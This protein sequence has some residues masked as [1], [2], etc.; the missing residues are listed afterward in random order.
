MKVKSKY[1]NNS[2]K[3]HLIN[4][5]KRRALSGFI[6]LMIIIGVGVIISGNY[7]TNNANALTY[8]DEIDMQFTFNPTVQIAVSGDLIIPDLAPGSSSDSNIITITAGSNDAHG[9]KLYG[10]VGSSSSNYTDLRLSSSNTTNVFTNLS[11]NKAALSNFSDNTWGYSYSTDSG[12]SWVSGNAGS[13]SSGY[14]GLP[15]YNSSNNASGV[16]LASTNS[17]S[18]TSLQ[19]KI[20]AKAASTQVSGTYTN[21]INFI[22]VGNVVT[23]T[24]SL[25]YVDASGEGMGLPASL[26]SQTTN[27]GVIT[28]SDTTP[29][30]T[31]YIF[32]GWCDTNNSSDPTTCSGAT[33]NPGRI[34]IIPAA[35][36]GGTVTVNM[37]AIWEN[38]ASSVLAMQD[39]ATWGSTLSTGDEVTATD[40]RDGKEYTV[41]KLADGNIWMTTNLNIAGGTELSS[42][43]TDFESTYTLPTTD[44][45]TTNN[46]KLVLPASDSTGF[47][48]D[49]YAYVYNTGNETSTCTSPGCYSYYSWDAATLGSGRSISTDNTDAPY[50][51]CPKGWHLPNTYNGSGTA[52]EATDFRALMIALGGS[53]SV[54][55]YDSSTT[56]TGETISS[57]LQ[58]DPYNFL[59]G[60]YYYGGSFT[61]GGSSG[62]YWSA[63]SFSSSTYAR[64]LYFGSTSVR[65][66]NSYNRRYGF[67]VRCVFGE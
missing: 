35:S 14:N 67:S 50:S 53:N 6:P 42:T 47:G 38:P 20:G 15:L 49:N 48:T 37:Y 30:R 57:A 32:K 31:N 51:I 58:A 63:T 33:Y 40:T 9:Y 39:V 56:P 17:A 11:S 19:F 5:A 4:S 45:W 13:T 12:S 10:T 1:I 16:I 18:E 44:G 2:K 66:A 34:Y 62:S 36:Q 7:T 52:A 3:Y 24:Y 59:L 64:N 25:N 21:T 65:S 26:S 55:T 27:D 28:L 61:N 54:Q 8:Q 46:G 22:G 60:G 29:T 23:T 41:A 43:D